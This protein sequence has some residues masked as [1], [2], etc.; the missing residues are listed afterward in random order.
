MHPQTV[1]YRMGQLRE[2]YGDRLDDP[3][4]V[5]EL[6]IALATPQPGG[7]GE[8]GGSADSVADRSATS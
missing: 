8:P 1:R 2:V 5:L 7:P 6:V 3:R 4:T